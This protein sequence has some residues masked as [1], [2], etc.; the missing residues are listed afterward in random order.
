MTAYLIGAL[1]F[2]IAI[3]VFVMQNT[4]TVIVQFINWTSPEISIALVAL[5]AAC[6]GAVMTFLFDSYRAFKAGQQMKTIIK[7]NKKYKK[8]LEG[9][10][11]G[12]TSGKS[13]AKDEKLID[14][15]DK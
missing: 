2:V 7:E 8:E 9:A 6:V 15:P 13:K 4:A 5:I 1:L 10:K 3:V 11:P 12:K 14:A